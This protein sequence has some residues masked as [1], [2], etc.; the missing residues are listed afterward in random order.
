MRRRPSPTKRRWRLTV[1]RLEILTDETT[2]DFER[3]ESVT[4]RTEAQVR[5]K[6]ANVLLHIGRHAEGREILQEGLR[7]L[8]TIDAFLAARLYNRLARV[9]L[10]CHEYAAAF[11]VFEAVLVRLGPHPEEL[12]PGLLDLWLDTRMGMVAIHY[13]RDEPDEMPALL[14]EIR[15]VLEIRGVQPGKHHRYY[16][17]VGMWQLAKKRHRID[18]EVLATVRRALVAAEESGDQTEY[19]G[20]VFNQGVA[21]ALGGDLDGAREWL[22]KALRMAERTGNAAGRRPRPVLPQPDRST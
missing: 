11:S 15:P 20:A 7:A 21:L 3:T 1:T 14:E 19:A 13:W 18:D 2:G 17:Q 4:T 9:E 10:D 22:T 16:M 6:L 5:L 12:E 8:G